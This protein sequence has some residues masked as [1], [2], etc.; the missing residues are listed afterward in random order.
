MP[1][2]LQHQDQEG[3]HPG[4]HRPL[5][6]RYAQ[7]QLKA[8]RSADKFG[9]IGGHGDDFRLYPV[10]PH[11]RARVMVA[12]LLGQVFTG[13]NAQFGRE[14]LDQHRHQVGPYYDPQ[15][16]IA[17]AGASLNIRGEITRIDIANG[18]DESGPH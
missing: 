14:H 5:Q 18:S 8:N 11:D 17:K 2:P 12:D 6:K 10:K 4:Q 16:L 9:Q 3:R 13:G 1:A 15:Q 7:H